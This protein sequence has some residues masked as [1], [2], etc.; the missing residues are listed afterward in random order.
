[1]FDTKKDLA[2]DGGEAIARLDRAHA[3]VTSAQRSLLESILQCDRA[4]VWKPEGFR[5][6]AHW[7]AA[8][9][10]TTEWG[11]RRLINA[12]HTLPHLPRTLEALAA[13]I[14]GLDKVV[15]L[16]RLA[17]PETEEELIP[18][19]RRVRPATIR[20]RADLAQRADIQDA[21]DAHRSR[22][23]RWWW[24]DDHTR[25]GFEGELPADQ[26]AILTKALD[27][28]AGRLPDVVMDD[29][30][31]LPGAEGALDRR[32]ADAL[33]ALASV[34]ISDDPDPDRATVVV[35]ADLSA[36][37]GDHH[38]CEIE[39]GG[40]IHPE[41]ARRLACDCRLEI[42]AHGDEG[43]A[44]GIG[45]ASR[46]P[47]RWLRRQLLHRDGGCLFPGCGARRFLHCHHV[48]HWTDGGRTDLDNLGLL[49]GFHHRLVH[50][51][52]WSMELGP[53]G[54]ATWFRPDG[55]RYDGGPAP[56]GPT[57]SIQTHLAT[58]SATALTLCRETT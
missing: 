35:H 9:L 41:T 55:S 26:G 3:T 27:R 42:I 28:M 54:S 40:L 1:M 16:C 43:A 19:A 20:Y 49:C 22:H 8:R 36:L 48:W 25:L 21:I 6:L 13:G 46:T 50:E 56:P 2:P 51:Y 52:G 37:T 7:L 33:V 39:G 58:W 18:W 53:P 11:A 10:G 15:E 29:D 44:V 17:T 45:R 23:L 32:R 24:S 31:E 47:P 4:E 14:L 30:F 5:N 38:H 57:E 34:R 12:A